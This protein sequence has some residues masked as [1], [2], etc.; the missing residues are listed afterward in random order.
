MRFLKV[1]P[2]DTS[3]NYF[4]VVESRI[5]YISCTWE[6]LTIKVTIKSA[7]S[8][9]LTTSF[10][11]SSSFKNLIQFSSHEVLS[12]YIKLQKKR[13]RTLLCVKLL[14][15]KY[16]GTG[17]FNWPTIDGNGLRR[18]GNPLRIELF[19]LVLKTWKPIFHLC[20]PSLHLTQIFN[21]YI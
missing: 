10:K 3:C 2:I 15:F 5:F 11:V 7:E 14:F 6:V 16:N 21:D 4:K 17:D 8:P 12:D 13:R 20:L 9:I 1:N 19:L 18:W